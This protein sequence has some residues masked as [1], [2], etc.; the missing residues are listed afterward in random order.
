MG[1][2]SASKVSVNSTVTARIR[3]FTKASRWKVGGRIR[4]LAFIGNPARAADGKAQVTCDFSMQKP[5]GTYSV[6]KQDVECLSGPLLGSAKTIYLSR[7]VIGFVGE[8]DDPRGQWIVR[9]I[10]KD[11]VKPAIIPL[12]TRFVLQ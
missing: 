8:K 2:R 11:L 4:V 10:I 5:D 12:E 6:Q 7:L 1:N 9:V 3:R